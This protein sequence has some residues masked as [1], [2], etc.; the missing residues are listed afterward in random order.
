MP[1]SCATLKKDGSLG[2][3]LVDITGTRALITGASSGIGR[4]LALA[5]TREGVRVGVAARRGELLDGLADEIESTGAPRP[6]VFAADLSKRGVA[7]DLASSAVRAMGA[8]DILINNAGA[9]VGGYQ[10]VIGDREE[11]R[12]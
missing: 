7:R 11:A 12:D 1:S 3:R 8:I 10:A 6:A 9:A 4:S 5:L 2:G